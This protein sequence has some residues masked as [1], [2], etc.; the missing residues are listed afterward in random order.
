MKMEASKPQMAQMNADA[1][2]KFFICE[3]LRHLRLT[4][5]LALEVE[6]DGVERRS[7]PGPRRRAGHKVYSIGENVDHAKANSGDFAIVA[8]QAGYKRLIYSEIHLRP[9]ASS[10]VDPQE[11][12]DA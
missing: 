1:R 6:F 9:S 3:D 10:A 2:R 8:S 12:C 11:G 4:N 5:S 7:N